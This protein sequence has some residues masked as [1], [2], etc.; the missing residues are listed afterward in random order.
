MQKDL[1]EIKKLL[2]SGARAAP[3]KAA[4]R[5]QDV[6]IGNSPFKGEANATVTLIEFSDYQC[7]YC[8]RHARNVMPEIVAE[9]VDTGKVKYVMFEDPIPSLHKNA[10]GA[11]Y[12]A[13]CAGDQGKYWEMHDIMFANQKGL[14]IDGL[15][16]FAASIGLNSSE[17]DTCL[18][19]KKFDKQIKSNIATAARVGVSG[20][21]GFV[22]GLTDQADPSKA[23]VSAYIKGAR[24]F[25]NFKAEIDKLLDSA[26]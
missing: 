19:N 13:L 20:T 10:Y 9:Y 6:S 16:S 14:D 7:P 2:R 25:D 4:F 11:S 17:F 22:V 3:A 5:E 8:S 18:D 12:A 21:P 24:P 1:E 23:R 26:K 15:K